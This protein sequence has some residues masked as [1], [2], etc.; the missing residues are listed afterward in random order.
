MTAQL[1]PEEMR[2]EIARMHKVINSA[3]GPDK[4]REK[5]QKTYL[6]SLRGV[7]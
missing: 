5:A 1:A 4:A 6:A 7:K 3:L 2:S